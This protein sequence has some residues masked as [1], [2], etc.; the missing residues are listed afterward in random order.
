[1]N[2][3][4]LSI[5]VCQFL[6]QCLYFSV[7]RSFIFLVKFISR[8]FITFDAIVNGIVFF[9][10]LSDQFIVIIYRC[11][12]F[13][14]RSAAL[15][16]HYLFHSGS[17]LATH[18]MSMNLEYLTIISFQILRYQI[19]FQCFAFFFKQL[20]PNIAD[21]AI[22]IS[23]ATTTK[24]LSAVITLF[25]LNL[26]EN[27]MGLDAIILSLFLGHSKWQKPSSV[28]SSTKLLHS[29]VKPQIGLY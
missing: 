17:L 25:Q 20:Q 12:C 28:R 2:R 29:T 3:R 14:Y 1:M 19:F 11:S 18:L 15:E 13:L 5:C 7:Y 27:L 24:L 21:T 16:F 22:A 9:I 6:H 8:Y 23:T 10:Y 26:Y 4:Y